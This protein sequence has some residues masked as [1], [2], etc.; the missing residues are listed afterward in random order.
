MRRIHIIFL[1]FVVAVATVS[2]RAADPSSSGPL[3][4]STPLPYDHVLTPM[5]LHVKGTHVLDARGRPVWL[6]GVNI[7]SL[8]WRTDG[9]HVQESANRAIRDWKVNLIRLPLAQ[10]RWFGK[11]E[12]QSDGGAGY[13][14]IVDR[15]VATCA[16]ARVYIDLDLHW[17]DCGRWVNEG[18]RLGQH[19]LP[20]QHSV[21]FWH[22]AARRYK[23]H[24]NVIFGLYNEPHDVTFAV[25]R[26]GGSVTD[27]PSM[28]SRDQSR[29][30]YQAVG[31][32]KL[33]DAA[34]ATGANN[35]V[36]ISGLDWGYDLSGVADGF[37][38]KGRNFVYETHPYP[39]KKDWDKCFGEISRKYAVYIGEWGAGG[40]TT[41]LEY[42]HTLIAYAQE[43]HLHWTAWDLH[44]SAGPTLIRNWSYEPTAFGAYVKEQ[45][46]SAAAER[47]ARQ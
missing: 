24:P 12:D 28:W 3:N 38:I 25:W 4:P 5:R 23:D 45:L 37:G 42:G 13:R 20:D 34:R 39:Q 35:L 26:D 27:T 19:S 8:E 16:V 36:T 18:G 21:D 44:T 1:F 41:N 2:I 40:G 22:D 17:S 31:M 10:D 47:E 15:L 14:S 43:H 9:D 46:A 33:Y 32:Q 7:A 6:Y 30:E 11:T 29:I